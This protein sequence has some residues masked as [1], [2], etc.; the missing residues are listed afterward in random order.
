VAGDVPSVVKG[1]LK[2]LQQVL[3]TFLNN[4]IKSSDQQG[5]VVVSVTYGTRTPNSVTFAVRD[6]GPMIP[7]E[8]Q[9]DLFKNISQIKFEEWTQSDR[10]SRFGYGLGLA[11]CKEIVQLHGGEI[12]CECVPRS[13]TDPSVGGNEFYVTIDFEVCNE[14][15]A[16]PPDNEL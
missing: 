8:V 13:D 15:D 16:A 2:M 6:F 1:D 3:G 7:P 10:E 9:K 11:I 4:A 12:G 5:D 14:E